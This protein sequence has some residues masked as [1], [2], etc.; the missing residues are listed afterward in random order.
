[1]FSGITSCF[2]FAYAVRFGDFN[3][4]IDLPVEDCKSLIAAKVDFSIVGTIIIVINVLS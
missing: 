4:R 2:F 1:M 3:Y